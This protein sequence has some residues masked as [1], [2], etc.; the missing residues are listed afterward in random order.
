MPIRVWHGVKNALLQCMEAVSSVE[1]ISSAAVSWIGA[2]NY[3]KFPKMPAFV[4]QL[5]DRTALKC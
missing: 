3:C 1:T 4:S 2:M 5:N